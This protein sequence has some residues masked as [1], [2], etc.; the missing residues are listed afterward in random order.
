M[1]VDAGV[2]GMKEVDEG[3]E[4]GLGTN[5]PAVDVDMLSVDEE[6]GG[7]VDQI[8]PQND[9]QFERGRSLCEKFPR[10]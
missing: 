7:D 6:E 1:V 10:R 3:E 9:R 5:P 4:E 2:D 8:I